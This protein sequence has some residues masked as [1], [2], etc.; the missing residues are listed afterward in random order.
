MFKAYFTS[1]G[2][3][4][5]VIHIIQYHKLSYLSYSL[6]HINNIYNHFLS[7]FCQTFAMFPNC[8]CSNPKYNGGINNNW[9]KTNKKII[10]KKSTKLLERCTMKIYTYYIVEVT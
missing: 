5:N 2:Y 10:E 4:T 1:G 7:T 6:I 3:F 8:I 9:M